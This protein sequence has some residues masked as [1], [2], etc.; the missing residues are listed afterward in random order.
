MPILKNL[1]SGKAIQIQIHSKTEA[2]YCSLPNLLDKHLMYMH[3]M[4]NASAID[5]LA[6]RYSCDDHKYHVFNNLVVH[7]SAPISLVSPLKSQRRLPP[8]ALI[9]LPV[10]Y[11]HTHI[12]SSGPLALARSTTPHIHTISPAALL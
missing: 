2:R 3:V 7:F 5:H 6:K 1:I 4:D 12:T 10:T 11:G 9:V 8:W